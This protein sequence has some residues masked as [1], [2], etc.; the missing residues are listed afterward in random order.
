MKSSIIKERNKQSH[1]GDYGKLLIVAGSF[2]MAGAAT[3]C[4]RAAIRSGVGLIRFLVPEE[5]FNILQIS[6]PEATCID[7]NRYED[8]D[9]NEYEAIVVGPGLGVRHENEKLFR[10]LF[11][12]YAG[13]LIVDADGL[14][15]I[16]H[17][18]LEEEVKTSKAQIIAT[19]HAGEAGRLLKRSDYHESKRR[20]WVVE[21]AEKYN[22]TAVLKGAGTIVASCGKEG[23]VDH[24]NIYVNT[25][26]N[27]GMATGGSGDVL[28]GV[29]GALAA[30]GYDV[31]DCCKVG[32]YVHGLAGDLCAEEVGQIGMTAM[33]IA[34]KMPEAFEILC[35]LNS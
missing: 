7:R 4:G 18:N 11:A 8:M 20:Q 16:V 17:F 21:L 30:Q 9:F 13:K 14:N 15:S 34:L 32:V 23:Q 27:P 35:K 24:N 29:I 33:D 3:M 2:G 22:C 28:A 19:P 12:E 6:V 5:L 1:K 10:K 25:T 31:L 26:G